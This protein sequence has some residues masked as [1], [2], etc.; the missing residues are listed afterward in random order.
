MPETPL[1]I[2]RITSYCWFRPSAPLPGIRFAY[3]SANE[4]AF[5]K[6]RQHIGETKN[7]TDPPASVHRP[8]HSRRMVTRRVPD[9]DAALAPQGT[10]QFRPRDRGNVIGA[11]GD[12][13]NIPATSPEASAPATRQAQ[14]TIGASGDKHEREADQVAARVVSQINTPASRAMDQIS[15]A[16]GQ[17]S[18]AEAR[19]GGLAPAPGLEA[20]I[21]QARGSGQPL[22]D[23]IRKP[24]EQAFGADFSRVKVHTDRRSDQL[25]R[26]IRARAFTAGQDVFLRQGGLAPGSREGQRLLA[27]ELTHV[28]QQNGGG[29]QSASPLCVIQRAPEQ[30]GPYLTSLSTDYGGDADWDERWTD[31]LGKVASDDNV[32]MEQSTGTGT[33]RNPGTSAPRMVDPDAIDGIN[34]LIVQ[35]SGL[36]KTGKFSADKPNPYNLAAAALG[37]AHNIVSTNVSSGFRK[38]AVSVGTPVGG[39]PQVTIEE[40]PGFPTVTQENLRPQRGQARRHILAWH[41]I[42]KFVSMAYNQKRNVVIGTIQEQARNA[43]LGGPD[44]ATAHAFG[45]AL[46]YVDPARASRGDL[47][48]TDSEWLKLGLFVMNGNPRNLWLGQSRANSTI[49]T[50]QMHMNNALN[51]V[52][53]FAELADLHGKWNNTKGTEIYKTA[54]R[55]GAEVLLRA[56]HE[57]YHE[58]ALTN[59]ATGEPEFVKK[60]VERVREWIISNLEIDVLGSHKA[61]TLIAQEKAASLLEPR[62]LID[63]VVTGTVPISRVYDSDVSSALKQ[64]LTYIDLYLPSRGSEEGTL[65]S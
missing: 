58:F 14:L 38:L 23:N 56:G 28:V 60:A 43:L 55:L 39:S 34:R 46:R 24:M 11:S 42:S 20:S 15:R 3:L 18:R 44:P 4:S 40:R 49:N 21:Q 45:E 6:A 53:K 52:T 22:A 2:D 41:D 25:N 32:T 27:H 33:R 51:G 64:F 30:V 61:Q 9:S 12:F 1:T 62:M 59:D 54:T 16:M 31:A 7:N 37:W 36:A 48:L 63:N 65:T 35:L 5:V 19:E 13:A 8:L 29:I 47:N 10:A 57:F 17:M 50:A 26:C